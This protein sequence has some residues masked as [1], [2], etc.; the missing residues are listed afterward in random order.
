MELLAIREFPKPALRRSNRS[1]HRK[2]HYAVLYIPKK[3]PRTTGISTK[4]YLL[5]INSIVQPV[6]HLLP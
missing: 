6:T 4:L 1:R 2:F 3:V 5:S